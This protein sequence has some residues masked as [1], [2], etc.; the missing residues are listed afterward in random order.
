MPL[1][2]ETLSKMAQGDTT[3][4]LKLY[5]FSKKVRTDCSSSKCYD[6][7]VEDVQI[8]AKNDYDALLK[9]EQMMKGT[10]SHFCSVNY[11]FIEGSEW[12]IY[13]NGPNPMTME[14]IIVEFNN[15]FKTTNILWYKC[16]CKNNAK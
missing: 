8:Y 5:K 15:D 11:N 13:F 4:Q 12:D 1:F 10:L 6:T 3:D 16:W 7:T 14:D 9:F 2:Y